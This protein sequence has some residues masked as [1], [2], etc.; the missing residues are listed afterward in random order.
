MGTI[1]AY[2]TSRL[3]NFILI[4]L[5]LFAPVF[6]FCTNAQTQK[7]WQWIKQLGSDSWDISAGLA[8][9]SK[10]NLYVI[11]SFFDTLKCNTKEVI[12]AG[13]QDIFAAVFNEDGDL[14]DILT[15]GGEGKDLATCLSVTPENNIAFGGVLSDTAIFGKINNPGTG[16]RLFVATMDIKGNFTWVSTI[17]ITGEASLYLI[18]S[19]N[20]SRIYIGGVFSGTLEAGEQKVVSNGKKDIFL[21]R[22]SKSGTVEKLY[23]LGSTEDDSPSSMSLDAMGNVIIAGVFNKSFE[24]GGIK[25]IKGPD[26]NKT[27]A[28]LAR[29]DSDFKSRWAKV[30]TSDDFC[31]IAS[32]KHDKSGNLYATGSFS[33]KLELADTVLISRGYT[34]AF[35]LK[36]TEEGSLGWSRS[37][38]SWYYDYASHV[39][40]DN[41][42]GAVITG[43]LGANMTLDSLNMEPLSKENSA[44]VIQFS[45]EGKA[46]WGDYISGS[47]RNFSKG[48]V[49]DKT[50]NL[51]FTGSFRDSFEKD[52]N[53]MT[54]FGDQDIFLA[55]FY[56]CLPGSDE[57]IGQAV[58]CPGTGTELSVRRGFTNVLWNDTISGKYSI[59]AD[60][61]G[62]YWVSMLDKNGCLQTDTILVNQSILPVFSLGK[63]TT[64]AVYDS[65]LLKVPAKY[66]QFRW[67]D[68]SSDPVYVAKS[69]GRKPGTI[70]YWLEVTDSLSCSYS[71]TITITYINSYDRI[72]LANEQLVTYPN[73]AASMFSW[74]LKTDQT[75]NLVAE[76][77]DE[78]GRII[79][80][81]EIDRYIPWEVR[82]ISL[83]NIAAGPYIFTVFDPAAGK[84]FQTVHIIKK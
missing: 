57:I 34:D 79:F 55:K 67:H 83:E 59:T 68:N 22:L 60:K 73:P 58:F 11:G 25:F 26:R 75:V 14:K 69:S 82:Q 9:D 47:G 3:I 56:N 74:Y 54:S 50:G 41:L 37:F 39:N 52:G 29:F 18:S 6:E 78:N 53:S 84:I 7:P 30:V 13:N 33:S 5:L 43:L 4:S 27:N 31:Q 21:G 64:I 8:C 16:Q 10:N 19:D 44:L 72:G 48:S 35:L 66:T 15:A 1:K 80:H 2:I 42:G 61:P 17:T 76:L 62:S 51:Y 20:Q 36:Y 40:V 24:A 81:K 38:G 28:F 46:I 65:L 45:P 32:L 77:S 49:L 71:D 12:S 70:P 63:D 23:S